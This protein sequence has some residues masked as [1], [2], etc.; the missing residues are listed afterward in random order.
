[1]PNHSPLT[2]REFVGATV[3][4]SVLAGLRPVSQLHAAGTG[5]RRQLFWGDLHNHNAVGYAKG[6][7]ERSIDLARAHL[8]FFA[9]TGHASWHDM[10]TMPGDRHMLWV[11]GFKA[12]RDHWEKTRRLMQ[13]ATTDKFT[14]LLGYE[15][16]SGVFGDYCMIFD[17]DQPELFLP[18]HVNKLLD[19][20]EARDAL[21]IPHHLGYL[22]GWRGANWK[23]FRGGRVSPVVE[24]MS[25][26]GC[27]ES[28]RG[29]FDYITHSQ[30]GRWTANT[31]GPHL[32]RGTRFGFVA[33][34]DD[35][36][37]YPGAYGEG[38]L[39]V[40]ADDL[41][42]RSL[43]EAIRARRT[44]ATSGERI[45]L[46]FTL[47]GQPMGAELPFSDER[48]IEVRVEGQDTIEMVELLRNGRV[49]QRHFPEDHVTG[50]LP[51]PGRA[52]CRLRYGWGPWGQLALDRVA[53]WDL[54]VR[55]N[56]GTFQRAIGC[57]QN[58]PFGETFRDKL[59]L[60]SATEIRLQSPTARSGS[61]RED[62][63]KSVVCDF[64]AQADAE[65]TV[66]VRQPAVKTVTARV[67]DLID[68]NVVTI[69]GAFPS[70]SFILERLVGP[71]ESSARIRW[72]DRQPKSARADYYYVRVRQHNG[73]VA[74]ASPIWVG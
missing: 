28:D 64:E 53:Q 40:W 4:A 49:I 66:E 8:D 1:M 2:R 41:R 29:P 56:R 47:N 38:V 44:Y 33:S 55:L 15:W 20:A 19:F 63:T 72:Q 35:H 43:F 51:L 21:A 25:E 7:L 73:H 42:G 11:N 58:A 6:S 37:G 12:H 71:S 59:T 23:Y 74:W 46:E 36:L 32:A 61:Y 10:P 16:H 22:E 52:K 34:S 70:E 67:R 69:M 60:V 54:T 24:I 57:F 50:R 27:T 26:H 17:Q 39:G 45:A 68:S 14:A 65:L 62:P 30:G 18:D 31:I 5:G 48:E 3:A 13:D 9:F